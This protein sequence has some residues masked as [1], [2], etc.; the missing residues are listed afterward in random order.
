MA[1]L[2][3]TK[4]GLSK[5]IRKFIRQEKARI[6]RQFLDFKKQEEIIKQLYDRFIKTKVSLVQKQVPV[7]EKI[8]EI[9]PPK[10]KIKKVKSKV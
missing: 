10:T 5:S 4:S 7:S 8:K 9:K 2:T 6:R 3:M 1:V